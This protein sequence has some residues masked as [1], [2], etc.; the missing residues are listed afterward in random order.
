[1]CQFFL[2]CVTKQDNTLHFSKCTG[3]IVP[4]LHHWGFIK[5][6]NKSANEDLH[7]GSPT[8]LKL[9]ATS[10]VPINAGATSLI[11]VCITHFWNTNF[12]QFTFHYFSIGEDIDHANVIFRTGPRA[13]YMVL[14]GD[15]A[16]AGTTLVT[17]DLHFTGAGGI[18]FAECSRI[19]LV[20]DIPLS[21]SLSRLFAA[22]VRKDGPLCW[23]GLQ[24]Q[25]ILWNE[26]WKL[27]QGSCLIWTTF[28]LTLYFAMSR[29]SDMRRK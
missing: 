15:L 28:W 5:Y 13:T 24:L 26:I 17:P 25:Y 21:M 20:S 23:L 11:Q 10:C 3:A 2:S 22:V 14:A 1:M 8:F 29:I 12:A 27:W 6:C 19:V 9:R 18:V 16:P 4:Q 7:Q